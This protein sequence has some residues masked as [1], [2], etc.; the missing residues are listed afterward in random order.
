M[1]AARRNHERFLA[2]DGCSNFRDVGGYRTG[3]G[4][5]VLPRRLFRS[6]SLSELTAPDRATLRDLGLATIVDLRSDAETVL[7]G[8]APDLG[9]Q[10]HHLPLGN[11]VFAADDAELWGTPERVAEFYFEMVAAGAEAIAETL[12][13]LTDP[14]AY[15]AVIHCS[16][17]KDRTGVAIA[18]VLSL[19]GIADADVVA[20]YALSAVATPHLVERMRE[21]L[22]DR[23]SDLDPYVPALLSARP[24][25]MR[26]FLERLRAEYGSIPRY[27]RHLG[28]TSAIGYLRFA[29]LRTQPA[30]TTAAAR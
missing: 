22:G 1:T 11:P 5:R 29:L 2:L 30:G 28:L 17:G 19:V 14:A 9:A 23:A 25:N 4:A 10:Y 18:L 16:V 6:D 20:D 27:V 7:A 13:I 26:L 21:R 8:R 12:A 24:D 15:P 3:A